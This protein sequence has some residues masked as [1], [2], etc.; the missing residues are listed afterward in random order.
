MFFSI[1]SSSTENTVPNTPNDH[2]A[3]EGAV[4]LDKDGVGRRA[5]QVHRFGKFH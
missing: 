5:A 4:E 3:N 2:A 1:L